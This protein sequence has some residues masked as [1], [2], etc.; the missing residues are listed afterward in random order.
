VKLQLHSSERDFET[1]SGYLMFA[2]GLDEACL[3]K[4]G[5]SI[6]FSCRVD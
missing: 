5:R 4:A 3:I 1:A 2:P 6:G